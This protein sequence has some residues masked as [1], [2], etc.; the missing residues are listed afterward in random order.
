MQKSTPVLIYR[1][2]VVL[3]AFGYW[4]YQFSRADLTAFGMQ[5]RFLTVW[6]LT[7]NVLVAAQMLRLSLGQA[8]NDWSAFVSLAVVMNMAVVVQYWRLYFIDP[9]S[10]NQSG[11]GSVWHQEYYLHVVGP[12]L[13][14]IDAFLILGVFRRIVPVVGL[15]LVLGVVYPA[16][17][18][19]AVAPMNAAPAG[20]VTSG[21]P[22]PFLNDLDGQGRVIFYAI[23]TAA[24]LVFMAVGWGVASAIGRRAR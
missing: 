23:S 11:H 2:C 21:L 6:A 12:L 8:R 20:T 9:A 19:F 13:M 3:L 7:A 18:E 5:F 24:N 17:I 22:Y 16:W 15:I 14:W 10:V 1:S 4:L